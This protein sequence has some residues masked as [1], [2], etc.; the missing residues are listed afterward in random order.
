[1]SM[2]FIQHLQTRIGIASVAM[3]LSSVELDDCKSVSGLVLPNTGLNFHFS[4]V[5]AANALIIA[6]AT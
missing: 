4:E 6:K 5:L 2:L 1:M 3:P